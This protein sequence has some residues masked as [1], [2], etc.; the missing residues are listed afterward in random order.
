MTDDAADLTG[1]NTM[2]EESAARAL[3]G[4]CSSPGLVRAILAGR[5]YADM[6]E[7]L[8]TADVALAALPESEIDLALSGHPRIGERAESTASAREQAG[9]AAADGAVRA[10][11]AEGNAAYER[12][13]GHIYLVCASDRSGAELLELLTTRLGNDPET[14][15]R[16]VRTELG[17]INRIRLRR[18]FG[19]AEPRW[20]VP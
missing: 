12:R 9:V 18:M 4:C 7:L 6:G 17:R 14:E 19:D 13:F 20:A 8:R 2:P 11:L 5:P 15:R 3:L 10:A 16:I 1:F